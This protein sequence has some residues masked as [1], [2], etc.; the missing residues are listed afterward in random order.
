MESLQQLRES[1]WYERVYKL[2]VLIKGLD[3]AVELVAGL[4]LVVSPGLL[5]SLLALII[6]EAHEHTGRTAR[7]IA[8]YVAHTD[9]DLAKGG[10]IFVSIFLLSHGIVKLVMVYCLLKEILWAYP[11]ALGVLVVF[12]LVQVYAC[13]I[14]PTVGMGIFVLLD[15]AIIWLVWGEWQKLKSEYRAHKK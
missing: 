8:E 14:K 7:F 2:G 6:G 13:I 3:G 11:Y 1:V 9:G 12:L 10:V 15:V 4:L 5:H